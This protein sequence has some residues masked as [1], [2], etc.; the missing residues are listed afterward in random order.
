M[1]Q[2]LYIC[3]GRTTNT[4]ALKNG[5]RVPPDKT[6]TTPDSHPLN[7]LQAIP[8][9]TLST[10]AHQLATCAAVLQPTSGYTKFP[11]DRASFGPGF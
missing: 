2:D 10:D 7:T 5:K 9:Q 8:V 3:T 1:L 11:G 6:P 4:S